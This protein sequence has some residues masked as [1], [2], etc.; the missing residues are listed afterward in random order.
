MAELLMGI[1]L[2]VAA[3]VMSEGLWRLF[4]YYN[5]RRKTR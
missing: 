5:Q 4:D 2:A 3:G 1:V